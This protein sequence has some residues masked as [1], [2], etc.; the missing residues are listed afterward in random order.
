MEYSLI[1]DSE[2]AGRQRGGMGLRRD[3]LFEGDVTFNVFADKAK[4][5]PKGLMG[6]QDAHPARYIRNPGTQS[7][8]YPSKL[9]VRL[10]PGEVFSVRMGGG[11]G[12]GSPLERDPNLVLRDVLDGKISVV[13]AAEVYG[14]VISEEPREV[15]SQATRACRQRLSSSAAR[16]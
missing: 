1:P 11:G 9:S 13:R 12:Y 5:T 10:Q 3:Y 6:G 14:V 4:F 16:S 2:G 7:Q 15:D 8:D